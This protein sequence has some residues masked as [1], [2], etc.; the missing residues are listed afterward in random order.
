M[1]TSYKKNHIE[2]RESINSTSPLPPQFRIE[3]V[4]EPVAQQ[5]EG[6][7]H[8]HEGEAGDGE[9]VRGQR[10]VGARVGEHGPPFGGGRGHAD[11]QEAE[12]RRH[13]DGG[14][15][16]EGGLYDDGAERPRKDVQEQHAP[17]R[18]ADGLG[19]LHEFGLLKYQDRTAHQPGVGRDREDAHSQHDVLHP[20]ADDGD[21]QNG[22]QDAREGERDVHD[23]HDEVV[24]PPAD[25]SADEPQQHAPER[26]D[27][28][29]EHPDEQRGARAV[30]DAAEHVAPE[31]VRPER[32]G[33]RRVFERRLE[34]RFYGIVRRDDGRQQGRGDEDRNENAPDH[35]DAVLEEAAEGV[36][37][38]AANRFA[39][40]FRR[41]GRDVGGLAHSP[42]PP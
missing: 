14:R 41:D 32:M 13:A 31:M 34:V 42:D 3:R 26:G 40:D 24:D 20:R 4:P 33:E 30:D 2:A 28:H 9:Q 15:D 6:E 8:P 18:A 10:H 5:V 7:H 38:H 22:E 17:A 27:E 29:G 11:A 39:F 12:S 16:Q 36:R 25:V 1:V 21:E 23:P 19:R 35:R 37:P